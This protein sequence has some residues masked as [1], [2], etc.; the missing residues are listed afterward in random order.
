MKS[1]IVI[2]SSFLIIAL[3]CACTVGGESE[4]PFTSSSPTAT[5]TPEP[6]PLAVTRTDL[7]AYFAPG[8]DAPG[9]IPAEPYR[10]GVVVGDNFKDAALRGEFE[11]LCTQ[12]A[13]AFSLD[14]SFQL[15]VTEASQ[16]T[17]VRNLLTS[18]IDLLI[19]STGGDAPALGALCEEAGVPYITM[20]C[21]AGTPGQG[22]YVCTV[23]RDE[24]LVG[25]LTGFSII[26]TLTTANGKPE[27]SIAEIVGDVTA[28]A[29]ILRSAGL[30]RAL[31]ACPDIH[32]VCSVTTADD[33]AYYAAT[34]VMKAYRQGEL[35]GIVIYSDE[36]ALEV[37]Q[38][39][40]NYER[41]DLR[42]RIWSVGGT[43]DGLTG[44]WYGE[45]AQTVE[46]TAQTGMLALEYAVQYLNGS[47]NIP[48]VVCSVTRAFSASSQ[49]QKDE[50]ARII[51]QMEESG[52]HS[53]ME[54]QGSYDLFMPDE[55]LT[56]IYPQ[57][58]YEYDDIQAYI[59]EFPPYTTQ[60][61][62]YESEPMDAAG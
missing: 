54:N 14:I 44:V 40:V 3:L 26:D 24:Y 47:G 51:A 49:E 39:V 46:L 58:Y 41:N 31:A 2:L 11:N 50:L 45:L 12:Y 34:N 10:I 55:R 18:G 38:A 8:L 27:G 23:E 30:R 9:A 59:D 25:L 5:V 62:G 53:C 7:P 20:D 56:L 36:A 13:D 43:K 19:L 21:R 61:A 15:S 35:D 52:F 1:G 4:A 16:Q 29:S 32:V 37:L 42:G 28:S 60:D 48:P 22:Q 6:A 57:H 33:T 17:I